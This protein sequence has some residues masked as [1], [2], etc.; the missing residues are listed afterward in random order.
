GYRHKAM[1]LV[2]VHKR[3]KK[4]PSLGGR[5][6]GGKPKHRPVQKNSE[7]P[8]LLDEVMCPYPKYALLQE[9]S[10]SCSPLGKLC[11]CSQLLGRQQEG[12]N[13]V[14]DR[15]H[16]SCSAAGARY[17]TSGAVVSGGIG[18]GTS[19]SRCLD[20]KARSGG[21]GNRQRP[22]RTVPACSAGTEPS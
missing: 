6:L 12:E 8:R 5:A 22:G 9:K 14:P 4:C 1:D 15:S 20:G 3:K 11:F 17:G 10:C 19:L 18:N 16:R 21:H 13:D 7:R 2:R